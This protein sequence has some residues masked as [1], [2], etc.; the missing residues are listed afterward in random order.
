VW[1]V[2]KD[3]ETKTRYILLLDKMGLH[4]FFN[5]IYRQEDMTAIKILTEW[6]FHGVLVDPYVWSK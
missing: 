4:E 1:C 6:W 3:Q 2:N 5:Y